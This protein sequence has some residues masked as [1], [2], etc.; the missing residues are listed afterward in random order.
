MSSVSIFK[1]ALSPFAVIIYFVISAASVAAQTTTVVEGVVTTETGEPLPGV[2]VYIEGTHRGTIT[3]A[4]G[5]YRLDRVPEGEHTVIAEHIGRQARRKQITVARGKT[6]QVDFDLPVLPLLMPGIVVSAARVAEPQEMMSVLSP[7]VVRRSPVRVTGELLRELPGVDA[8]RRGPVGLDPVIRGLRETEIGVYLDGTRIFPGGSARM[9]SPLSHLDPSAVQKIQVIKGP[10]ALTWG[11]GNLSAIRVETPDVPLPV[12]GLLH[13]TFS[14]SYH[15]NLNALQ[16]GG[17]LFGRRGPVSYWAHAV[18]RE[19]DD[20]T[21][22]SKDQVPSDFLTWELRGKV[23]LQL[24]PNSQLTLSLG[25]QNQ[26][27]IDYPGRLLNAAFFDTYNVSARWK[28]WRSHGTLRALSAL[29]YFNRVDH[30]MDNDG[31]PTAQPDPNRMPPFPLR[32]E[33]N[34]GV[35]VKGGRLSAELVPADLWRAEIGGDVYRADRNAVRQI[36]RRDTGQRLFTDLMWPDA[37]VTD[38]GLFLRLARPLGKIFRASGTVRLDMVRANADTASAFF[39]ENSSANLEASETHLSGAVT[40]NADLTSHW[41]LSLGLGTAVRTADATERYSDRIPASKAQT[42]AEFMGN[43]RLAPE[44]ST[45]VDLWVQASYPGLSVYINAFARRIHDYITLE[46]TDLPKRLPLSPPIVFRYVNGEAN[47]WGFEASALGSITSSLDLKM[48]LTYLWGEDSSLD[49]PALG[50]QPVTVVVGLRYEP[51]N[52][53]YFLAGT[54][55]AVGQQDRVARSRGELPTSGYSVVD[56]RGG[57]ELR[58]GVEMRLGVNNLL[59]KGY[60]NHLNARNP[61]TGRQVPEPGRVYFID[62]S[63]TL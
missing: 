13:G 24:A 38:A 53:R 50:I 7:T 31:K 5:R 22:G 37:T 41:L 44:R 12:E 17:S 11:A 33:V 39:L 61:F 29:V 35:R 46:P 45:Q 48:G 32:V 26:R 62:V 14:S 59:D 23:G 54:I 52:G 19:G 40:V 34:S 8:V 57:I 28:L 49:E 47:F 4:L 18:W 3:D 20:Y 51:P 63:Y 60:V 42:S 36:S 56:L 2:N 10:Y 30:G 55:H 25:Y 15:A 43:P 1:V 58:K 27:D 16:T 21:S 6:I 9:D